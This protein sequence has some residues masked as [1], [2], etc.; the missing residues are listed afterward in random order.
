MNL[1]VWV[2]S[3]L[4]ALAPVAASAVTLLPPGAADSTAMD[5][6]FTFTNDV[7]GID[8]DIST[9]FVTA[10]S[11]QASALAA[12]SVTFTDPDG[13]MTTTGFMPMPGMMGMMPIAF[14][15]IPDFRLE[16]GESFSIAFDLMTPPMGLTSASFTLAATPIPLPAAGWMLLSALGG[17]GI[18]ARRRRSAATA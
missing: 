1:K 17:M 8:L 16:I 14:V 10:N 5:E 4:L 13:M 11:T 2:A 7:A 9:F 3:L 6:T 18:L 15:Q 12:S